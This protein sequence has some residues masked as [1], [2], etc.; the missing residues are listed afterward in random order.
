MEILSALFIIGCLI[1]AYVFWLRPILK[2]RPSLAEFYSTTDSWWSALWLKLK[3]IKTRFATAFGMTAA[4]IVGLHDFALPIT[5]GIDWT[6]ITAHVPSWVWPIL[7]FAYLAMISWFRTLTAQTNE[8]IVDAV[9]AGSTVAE[10]KIE[11]GVMPSLPD[12][13]V[14]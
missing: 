1:A 7:T 9:A 3:T 12:A 5:T 2:Q 4:G 6:P 10:A 8:K 13:E 11:A 14:K